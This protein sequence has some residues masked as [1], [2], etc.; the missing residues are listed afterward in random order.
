M[1]CASLGEFE[2][3]RPIIEEIKTQYPTSKIVLTFF[4]PSGYEVRKNYKGADYVMYL[5][6]D[7]SA[8]AKDF[9]DLVK[10]K[11]AI[12]V[13]YEFWHYYL[14]ELNNR[15]IETILVSGIFRPSQAF[16]KW[17]R[18]SCPSAF[19]ELEWLRPPSFPATSYFETPPYAGS[20]C[21]VGPYRYLH[22]PAS[23]A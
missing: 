15:K 5:P 10:P 23:C 16:F 7:S 2:Q 12:F 11:L 6:M 22:T 20:F 21:R 13:K 18:P 1:H 19:Q 3:G 14:A 9:L 4:S 17:C 8:N